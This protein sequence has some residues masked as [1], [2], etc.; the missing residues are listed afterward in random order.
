MTAIY[1]VE[2]A[3]T[4]AAPI[5]HDVRHRSYQWLVDLD[6]LP[7][8]PRALRWLARFDARDHDGRNH[9]ARDD[10]SRNRAGKPSEPGRAIRASVEDFLRS[11]GVRPPG[12][13]ITMLAHARSAGYVFNPLSVF[14]CHDPAGAVVA[15]VLEVHNTYGGAHRYL[16]RPDD[17]GRAEVAKDFYVSPFYPVD[18]YYRV[19]APEPGERLAITITLHRPGDRPFTATVR[20]V[21]RQA[22][23]AAVLSRALRYPVETWVIRVLI[24]R[25]GIALWRAGLPV[26]ARERERTEHPR[27]GA[28]AASRLARMVH[29]GVGLEL[30]LRIRAWDGSEAGPAAGPVVHIRS[31]RVLRRL[32]WAPS[33][34]GLARAYVAGDLDVSGDGTPGEVLTDAL[35]RAWAVARRQPPARPSARRRMHAVVDAIR[36]G[37]AGPPPQPPAAEAR[38]TGRLHSRSRDRSAISHHY[39]L[40]ND[41]YRLLLDE[42]MAYSCAYPA[43]PEAS[44]ADAQR[45][46]LD[47]ICHKLGLRPGQRLL[48]VGC[49]WGSLVVHAA[50]HFGV[51]ATG[52]TLSAEQRDF[53]AKRVAERGLSGQVAVR[54]Q[55]YRDLAG[56]AETF[57][58]V[59]SIEMGEHVGESTYATFAGVL[60]G[61]LRPGGR[62]LLQQMSRGPGAAPGGGAFIEAY[63]APD[64]HMRPVEQTI[65][66]LTRTGFEVGDVEALGSQYSWTAR[67]WLDRF[68]ERHDELVAIAG[69]EAARVWRLYLAGGELSF[70]EGR[71]GVEQILAVRPQGAA[72]GRPLPQR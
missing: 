26:I 70:E 50:E 46:K 47:L 30:P 54:L 21:R 27:R 16:L 24:A 65:A 15:T 43:T 49:G 71:M 14:W 39:D 31:R 23:T 61:A 38:L 57:D 34:L 69:V 68:E 45:A 53:V 2:I 60:F 59:S 12:G 41:F 37:A 10:D 33:E 6:Q 67:R 29:D 72:A 56:R 22:S 64:M 17:A 9:N 66:F 58:A 42:S 8:L 51:H 63:I 55:D 40:S 7:R 28:S 36:L 25:H 20:G 62:L 3:H 52:I 44:L 48:D 11:N 18:G 19:S 1:D 32:L 4:R 35:R 5:R 13:R